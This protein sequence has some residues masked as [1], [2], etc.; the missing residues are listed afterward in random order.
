[1]RVPSCKWLV[2]ATEK[3]LLKIFFKRLSQSCWVV[4]L[5]LLSD[6]FSSDDVMGSCISFLSHAMI[7]D[8]FC[9]RICVEIK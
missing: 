6:M 3:L 2:E 8:K 1:M 5:L 7:W 4:L 9:N